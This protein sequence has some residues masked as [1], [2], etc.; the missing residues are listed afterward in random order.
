MNK[1]Q[2]ILT[3][4]ESLKKE[5]KIFETQSH[6]RNDNPLTLYT[7]RSADLSKNKYKTKEFSFYINNNLINR[8]DFY[9][10]KTIKSELI[11]HKVNKLKNLILNNAH[12]SINNDLK[13][14]KKD[15]LK[16]KEKICIKEEN[17]KAHI[18]TNLNAR[19]EYNN[20]SVIMINKKIP[21][22]EKN[23]KIFSPEHN[24]KKNKIVNKRKINNNQIKSSKNLK[25]K[26]NKTLNN[27]INNQIKYSY[28]A[29]EIS[30]NNKFSPKKK[31]NKKRKN[32]NIN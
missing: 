17:R 27:S 31:A 11:Q 21:Q 1:S 26:T 10:N 16:Q 23:L 12:N 6:I 28:L 25:S 22:K 15:F 18:L 8:N 30:N 2:K 20:H 32:S 7:H 5:N 14:I 19:T 24:F 13:N 3:K 4:F 29:I 9:L